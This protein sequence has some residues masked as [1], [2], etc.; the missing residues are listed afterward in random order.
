MLIR[1]KLRQSTPSFILV[2]A[3]GWRGSSERFCERYV[4]PQV[5]ASQLERTNQGRAQREREY[6][7][8]RAVGCESLKPCWAESAFVQSSC[9]AVALKRS[10]KKKADCAARA[11]AHRFGSSSR[12]SGLAVCLHSVGLWSPMG[13]WTFVKTLKPIHSLQRA[14]LKEHINVEIITRASFARAQVAFLEVRLGRFVF[15]LNKLPL[16][17]YL[18]ASVHVEVLL[19]IS[20][21]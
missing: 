18:H 14:G 4:L 7:H 12:E 19:W 2:S 17:G 5:C 16:K 11:S 6:L 8:M 10:W 21:C 15:K 9:E 1:A 3:Y 20:I 13:V